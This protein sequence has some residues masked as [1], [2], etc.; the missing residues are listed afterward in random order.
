MARLPPTDA[1]APAPSSQEMRVRLALSRQASCSYHIKPPR[2]SRLE[3]WRQTI[4]VTG[5]AGYIGSLMVHALVDAD[6]SVFMR[7]N[8]STG[9]RFPDPEQ[10]LHPARRR[11]RVKQVIFSSTA[12]VY[13]NPQQI[14][15]RE[16]APTVP[17]SP[18]GTSKLMSEIMLHDPGKAY[19]LRF[20]VLRYFNVAGADPKLRT[21]QSTPAAT[22]L[23][24]VARARNCLPSCS[25]SEHLQLLSEPFKPN[26][27]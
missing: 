13:G 27:C 3:W 22:H 18:Y 4:L 2:L 5:G 7:D 26:N 1:A 21:G 6:E 8:L 15:V 17:I 19:G 25:I 9:L 24:K 12:A 16:D 10:H 11:N 20:V 14:P 23:I